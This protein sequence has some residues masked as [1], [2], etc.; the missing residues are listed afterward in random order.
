MAG[1]E[2]VFDRHAINLRT[3]LEKYADTGEVFD[4]KTV[5]AFYAHDVL[6]ELAFSTQFNS[7][8][9]DD[10]AQLPPINDHIF[11][12]TLYGSLP[13]LLPYSMRWSR[14]L[15]I[16]WLQGLL[17]SRLKIRS[18]VSACVAKEMSE[19][20]DH[21]DKNKNLLTQLIAA[22]DPET[23][24]RLTEEDIC[25]EAFGF[26]VAGTHTTSATLT[27]LFYHLLHSGDVYERLTEEI[28][29]EL[30]ALDSSAAHPYTGLENKLP[31]TMAC[32]RENFR[33][34]P[35][36]TMPLTRTV[37]KAEGMEIDGEFIPCGVCQSI[38]LKVDADQSQTNCS[39]SNYALHHNP[40]IWG[41]E[42]DIFNPN[43]WLADSYVKDK[44]NYLMPFGMGHRSCIGRNVA[45]INIL[46]CVTIIGRHFILEAM[47]QDE[48]LDM[49][50]VGVG[51]K[52][53]P[54]VCRI[55]RK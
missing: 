7:Q 12:A 36:F 13:S 35:V 38:L 4:L 40:S 21:P 6:G 42:H 55:R 31:F 41:H 22:K 25:S 53:G 34:T 43:R 44:L 11:L 10:P 51:G 37:T 2:A 9:Q 26:L 23:G 39:I 30:P 24:V 47:E 50:T 54:L 15:P 49:E 8:T 28:E 16:R 48:L 29:Q 52:K 3:K 19:Q 1:M 20:K 14:H 17:R 46:K 27:L 32:I 45:M 18:T 5:F 33:C